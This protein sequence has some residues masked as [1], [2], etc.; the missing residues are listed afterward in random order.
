MQPHLTDGEPELVPP[1]QLLR[2]RAALATAPSPEARARHLLA[3]AAAARE[4]SSPA[5]RFAS[6]TVRGAAAVVATLAITSGLAAA[7]VLP[8][9]AQRI[10]SSVSE[11]FSSNEAP[12]ATPED[13]GGSGPSSDG[14]GLVATGGSADVDAVSGAT[15]STTDAATPGGPVA[16]TTT[17]TQ[18]GSTTTTVP[19]TTTTIPGP[20]GPGSPDEP[21][22][23]GGTDGGPTDPGSGG[24]D[25]PTDPGTDGG[26]DGS[27]GTTEITVLTEDPDPAAGGPG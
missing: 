8:T 2:A 18:P 10:F 17:T 25:G 26:T 20:L 16:Q 22:E 5:S 7:Q 9:P 19:S 21:S 11:R 12:P 27:V 24:D 1:A 4:H 15:T 13:T 14:P 23:P 3:V 6:R